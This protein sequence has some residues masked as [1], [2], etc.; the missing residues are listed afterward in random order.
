MPSKRSEDG[1]G[2][3]VGVPR[4]SNAPVASELSQGTKL[5]FMKSQPVLI[6]SAGLIH[7]NPSSAGFVVVTPN[8]YC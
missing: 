5:P 1:S 4:I 8:Q 2:V 7:H 3:D 6:E